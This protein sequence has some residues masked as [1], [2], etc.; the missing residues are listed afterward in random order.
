MEYLGGTH[1]PSCSY[2][3]RTA[4]LPPSDHILQY[5]DF[6]FY[7]SVPGHRAQNVLAVAITGYS[8]TSILC[9]LAIMNPF[10]GTSISESSKPRFMGI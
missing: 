9:P 6:S 1:I 10:L 7:L 5:D 2:C 4:L 8:L 3:I